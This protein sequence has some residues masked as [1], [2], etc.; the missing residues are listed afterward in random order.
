MKKL[1]TP[2][3]RL[4]LVL[5]I[6]L[7]FGITQSQAESGSEGDWEF[8][9][10][11]YLWGAG[12]G[13]QSGSGSDLDI[14]FDDIFDDLKMG[15]MGAAAARKGKWTVMMDLIYL[16][17]EDDEAVNGINTRVELSSWII[18]PSVGYTVLESEQGRLNLLLGAR[19]L[20]LKTDMGLGNIQFSDS[21][22]NWDGIIGIDGELNLGQ[23][24]YLPYYLD[25]GT[26]NSDLTWQGDIGIGYRFNK[27]DI[28]LSYRYLNYDFDEG[29]V[30]DNM[31]ISG[32]MIGFKFFF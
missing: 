21:G 25:I 12:I 27:C 14:N 26:G 6:V 24:W 19:Y 31:N 32:P 17:I 13:G 7:F 20:Y 16:D 22:S 15:F 11:I 1:K 3:T 30:I 8:G 18:T 4:S 28:V 23:K 10:Q 9:A 2:F 5:A 29:D